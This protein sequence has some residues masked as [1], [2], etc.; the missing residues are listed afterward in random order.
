MGVRTPPR[1]KQRDDYEGQSKDKYALF[2]AERVLR[3]QLELLDQ[4]DLHAAAAHAEAIGGAKAEADRVIAEANAKAGRVIGAAARTRAESDR[5][6]AKERLLLQHKLA[7]LN[8]QPYPVG[9]PTAK[10]NLYEHGENDAPLSGHGGD[11]QP[12]RNGR[13]DR[14]ATE[15]EHI[16]EVS[17]N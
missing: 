5:A 14:V 16:C 8:D 11:A 1:G 2:G 9:T 6:V 7:E 12:W 13:P 4:R 3:Q 17:K 10:S 15:G